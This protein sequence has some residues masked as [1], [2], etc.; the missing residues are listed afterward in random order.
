MALLPVPEAQAR[1]LALAAPLGSETVPLGQAAR[2][3]A[4]SDIAARRNQPAADLS[5]MDGYAIRFA[6]LPGPWRVVGEST[7]GRIPSFSVEQGQAARIFTGAALPEGADTILIQENAARDGD[8]LTLSSD[9]PRKIGQHVRRAGGDFAREQILIAKGDMLTPARIALAALGGHGTVSVGGR[10]RVALIS[11]GDE[12]VPPGVEA[13]GVRLP[14]SNAIMLQSMLEPIGAIVEDHGIVPDD[15]DTL[16][17]AFEAAREADIVVTT[18]GA[19]VG[20]HDLVKPVLERIGATLDFWKI[21]M[22]PGKPLM[23]GRLGETVVIGLPG[24]PVSSF[25]TATLFVAPLVRHLQGATAVLPNVLQARLAAPL[26]AGGERAEYLR[27]IWSENGLVEAVDQDSAA[28]FSLASANAL[29]VRAANVA[30][31]E[32]GDLA[33]VITLT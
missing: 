15:A 19:S 20:D 28:M 11:T 3:F 6:D 8:A 5:A 21:A 7:P 33:S 10:P 32:P 31:A 18:G 24:N 29:I 17:A 22:R 16:A 26:P 14:A 2:R 1:M 13:T 25:V 30:P 9:A 4:A 27:A 12:L 23:A